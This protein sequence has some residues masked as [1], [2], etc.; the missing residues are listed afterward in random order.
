MQPSDPSP[1]RDPVPV[2]AGPATAR[3]R[4]LQT[5]RTELIGWLAGAVAHDVNNVLAAIAGYAELI[6]AD[7]HPDDP[8][9][10]DAAGIRDAV[11]RA[12]GL[13]R[14]L[15][16]VGRR[17]SLRLE[18]L[19]ASDVVSGLLPLVGSVCGDRIRVHLAVDAEPAGILVDRSL[20]EQALL[21]LAVNARDAMPDGGSLTMRV[22]NSPLL[23]G[24]ERGA[25]VADEVRISVEDTGV[26]IEASVLPHV[27][28][29][30]F[31]TKDPDRGSGIGLAAVEEAAS[32]CGGQVS[33]ASRPGHG[34]RFTLHF[35]RIASAPAP[36]VAA[37]ASSRIRGGSETVL[38]V[39]AD[40]E[41]RLL[42][43]RLMRHLGYSVVDAATPSQALAL[44]GHAIDRLDLLVTEVALPEM[45]GADLAERVRGRH[46]MVPVLYLSRAARGPARPQPDA[47]PRDRVL[48][49]PFTLERLGGAM[50]SL[51]DA[52]LP[53]AVEG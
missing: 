46:P 7:L 18:P 2:M 38:V 5:E 50:R 11:A 29:P 47:A 30:F 21:N 15:L 20:L 23:V 28:E 52:R 16:M 31:S 10:T 44:V 1:Q 9:V 39:D 45:S 37:S 41:V 33:V 53:D 6:E 36:V 40:P 8:H 49:K 34:T 24:G 42:L 14:Q 25:N 17:Q 22:E 26:G 4:R 51:L 43:A 12:G 35:P 27:F 32:R 13:V 48:A 3:T 19:D